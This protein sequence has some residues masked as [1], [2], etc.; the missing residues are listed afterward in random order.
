MRKRAV[1]HCSAKTKFGRFCSRNAVEGGRCKQHPKKKRGPK[2]G[3]GGRPRIRWTKTQWKVFDAMCSCG[4]L[5][6]DIAD[7]LDLSEDVV[8]EIC[9]REKG[10]TF[11]AYREGKKAK[12]RVF[13][14]AKQL[15]VAM[16]GNTVMLKHLGEHTLGQK[17][18]KGVEHEFPNKNGEAPTE[19]NFTF[20]KSRHAE[21]K[22]S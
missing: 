7:A 1:K 19:I 18:V 21:H 20:V 12:G 5:Q 10:K 14:A 17:T 13:L 8:N 15:E 6:K 22:P 9:K 2:K 4:A 11:K 3:E 16:T